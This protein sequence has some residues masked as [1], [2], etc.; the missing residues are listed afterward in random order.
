MP[1]YRVKNI[2]TGKEQEVLAPTKQIA[3][4]PTGWKEKDCLIKRV[5]EWKRLRKNK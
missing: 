3:I 1:K 5:E 2:E 4:A